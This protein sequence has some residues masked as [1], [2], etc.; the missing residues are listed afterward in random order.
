MY[1]Q[2]TIVYTVYYTQYIDRQ[3][4]LI[5]TNMSAPMLEH[6]LVHI[7][8]YSNKMKEK[9]PHSRNGSKIQ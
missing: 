2:Y 4:E 3:N 9:I 6:S 5:T 1:I 7:T 8:D